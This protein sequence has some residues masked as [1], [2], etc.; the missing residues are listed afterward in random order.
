MRSSSTTSYRSPCSGAPLVLVTTPVGS[1]GGSVQTVLRVA[2]PVNVRGREVRCVGARETWKVAHRWARVF[3]RFV[4]ERGNGYGMNVIKW[5][6]WET[7]L[8]HTLNSCLWD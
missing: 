7:D 6:S 2:S 1:R 4:V 5:Q 3:N 8:T